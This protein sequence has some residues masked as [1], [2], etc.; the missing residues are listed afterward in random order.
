M[1]HGFPIRVYYEDTDCAGV[2]YHANYLKFF[3]RARTEALR[4]KGFELIKLLQYYDAQ[5]V[6]H[7]VNLKFLQPAHLDQL[8]YIVTKVTEVRF[9]SIKY[10]QA[11]YLG[12]EQGTLLCQA[13]LP[14]ACLNSHYRPRELPNILLKGIK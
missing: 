4:L 7:S 13:D 1:L 9:A 11:A 2:M 3:E 5:F 10:T 12:N 8:L 14:I 6:V